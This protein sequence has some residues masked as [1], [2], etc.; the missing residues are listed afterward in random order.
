MRYTTPGQH[1]SFG[2]F[3]THWR[4]I[5]PAMD[6]EEVLEGASGP[7]GD[8]HEVAGLRFDNRFAIHPMEGWDAEPDG[9]PSELTLRRWNN[10][11][12]SGA[13]MLWGGEAF[14]VQ[15]DGRA[16]PHQLYLNDAT[17]VPASL[18]TLRAAVA[19]GRGAS[20]L[21]PD[22]VVLGLQLT[23]SGRWSR[24]DAQGLAPRVAYEHP[25]LDARVSAPGPPHVLTDGELESIAERYVQAARHAQAAGF[26]FVDLKCC[27]GYLM[28]ELLSARSR[29]GPYGGSFENRTRF[30]TRLIDEVRSAC[31]GLVLAVRIS[32]ADT[33]PFHPNDDTWLG[34]PEFAEQPYASA[35][36]VDPNKPTEF[37]LEEPKRLLALLEARDIRLVN[38]TLGSP[39]A[40]PHIQRPASYPP[41]DGYLPPEDPLV[42]VARH[43]RVTRRVKRA[44]PKLT[45]VGTGYSY[46]QEFL[47][48]VAQH[49]VR[50]GHVDFVGLGRM[51]LSYPDLPLDVLRGAPMARKRI[52]RTFSDCT[53]APRHG[54]RSGCYPLDPVY[55]A[56]EDASSLGEVKKRVSK[57]R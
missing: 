44:F 47:P 52:C 29:P 7:L 28:H 5:D 18:A 33:V 13:A 38:L 17:D 51:V 25:V 37:D 43:L 48:N 35:F 23:H 49:E 41:S 45:I 22:A 11:G 56:L 12:R 16:N 6:A 40:N 4:S 24:P 54:L 1:K 42:G 30:L 8:P 3:R 14:A 55:R 9:R 32:I 26:D 19:E 57:R 50:G 21:D 34:E 31:P 36:G 20:A 53:T 2:A 10:F 15:A 46:L 27:H 39:Y